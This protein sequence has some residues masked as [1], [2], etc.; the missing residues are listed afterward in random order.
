MQHELHLSVS[1]TIYAEP[2]K[3][4]PKIPIKSCLYSIFAF[5]QF[6]SNF[7]WKRLRK[8]IR[9]Y[10]RFVC[11]HNHRTTRREEEEKMS[12]IYVKL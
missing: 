11:K 1:G 2:H 8:E 10:V 5:R 6:S 12:Q 9:I 4:P 3:I 7:L